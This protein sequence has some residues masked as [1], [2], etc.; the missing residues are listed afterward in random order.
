MARR[1]R[2]PVPAGP[3]YGPHG[4]LVPRF[5][6]S[7]YPAAGRPLPPTG[8]LWRSHDRLEV[9]SALE[10][11]PLPGG[12]GATGPQWHLSV[13]RRPAPGP[14]DPEA[15]RCLVATVDLERVVAAFRVPAFDE[16][17]H[18]PGVARHLWCPVDPAYRS[19][20]E[21]KLTEVVVVEAG[22]YEW[23]NDETE[24]CRGCAY[25]A[26]FGPDRYPCT[27]HGAPAEVGS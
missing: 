6:F 17:N 9:I 23:S 18:H 20:C 22:G 19:A 12:A 14:R 8:T 10:V 24:G 3:A 1:R 11:A 4:E 26:S 5:G 7:R 27:I 15:P 25:A 13:S 2:P 21:C 16:D